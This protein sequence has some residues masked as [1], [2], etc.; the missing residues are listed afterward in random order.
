MPSLRKSLSIT[1]LASN[2]ATAI[3][4]LVTI[5]LARLLTPAEIGIFSIAYVL[6]SVAHIFRDFGVATY[7]VQEKDLTPEKIRSI[8]GVL[9]ASSWT[10]AA[11]LY[12]LSSTAA[13]YYRQPGVEQVIEV[14]AMG[15]VFIPFGAITH[16]LLTR[17][18]K[19]REQAIASIL[20][21][22][23][24]ATSSIVLAWLGF[25]YMTMAW[26]SLLNIIATA[27]AYLPFRPKYAPWLPSFHGWGRVIHFSSG[28]LF[29]NTVKELNNSLPDFALGKLSGPH[30]V[31]IMSRANSTT[32]L[33]NMIIGPT[34]S[35]AVLPVLSQRHHAG[36][37]IAEPMAK[38]IAYLTGLAWPALVGTAIFAEPIILFLFGQQWLESAP[39]VR[40][41]CAIA[42]IN[43]PF[44]FT[45]LALQAM[46]RPYL[47][48][49][50][51]GLQ[52]LFSS[53]SILMFF[54]QTLVS[55]AYALL[56]ANLA[57]L[58]IY[59]WL[60]HHH[61]CFRI[62]GFLSALTKSI[63]LALAMA[64]L[65]AVLAWRLGGLKPWEQVVLAFFISMLSWG[66]LVFGLFHPIRDEI[67][68]LGKKIPLL[69]HFFNQS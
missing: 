36:E 22:T 13:D 37:S 28:V 12:S 43:T 5:V 66:T 7:L 25:S 53:I 26:A 4:F 46:G 63:P 16:N 39:L 45:I 19:A 18:L 17:E 60:Q 64:A 34:V 50:P 65:L 54:D 69:Q 31:G 14:L 58:P 57:T 62:Q 21:V 29:S 47:A 8:S 23:V 3:N 20:G 42:F 11:I 6:V 67:I 61:M 56:A 1:F 59:L 15:F 2:G 52:L 41:I 44:T 32:N 40:I 10:T 68:L 30:G 55:F 9:F 27:I 24:F 49:V 33:F 35:Y 51:G 38:A 48:A